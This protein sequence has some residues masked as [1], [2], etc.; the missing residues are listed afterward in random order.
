MIALGKTHIIASGIVAVCGVR[1]SKVE[2]ERELPPCGWCQLIT[3]P[4]GRKY[5]RPKQAAVQPRARRTK[6]WDV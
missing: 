3:G 5:V 6:L 2:Y 1:V 4:K